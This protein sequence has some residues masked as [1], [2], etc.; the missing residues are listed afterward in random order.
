MANLREHA[1]AGLDGKR[2]VDLTVRL[3]GE[4][5]D[6]IVAQGLSGDCDRERRS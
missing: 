5:V 1:D 2:L 6:D 3:V 4:R